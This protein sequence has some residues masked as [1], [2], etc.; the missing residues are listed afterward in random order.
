MRFVSW[1]AAHDIGKKRMS[2]EFKKTLID[3][4]A[5]YARVFIISESPLNGTFEEFRLSVSPEKILDVLNLAALYIG[6]G[7]S[8]A[9][10]AAI[11]GTPSIFVSSL[12][13][14]VF[15]ELERNY[16]LM[17]TFTP[18]QEEGILQAV[19]KIL[20][21]PHGKDTWRAKKKKFLEDKINVTDYFVETILKY[22]K[23]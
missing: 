20:K 16:G 14:G 2:L 1:E 12:T 10:E 8:M 11:L 7:G 15:D 9:T 23:N 19:E 17:M 13:A 3:L 6:D 21:D 22:A 4:C 18:D 5:R